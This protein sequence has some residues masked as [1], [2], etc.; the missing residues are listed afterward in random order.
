MIRMLINKRAVIRL[1]DDPWSRWIWGSHLV[2]IVSHFWNIAAT[3]EG[4]KEAVRGFPEQVSNALRDI[5]RGEGKELGLQDI[6]PII[7]QLERMR[8]GKMANIRWPAARQGVLEGKL[9]DD[10]KEVARRAAIVLLFW[11]L[12][13]VI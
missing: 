1:C 10:S 4:G 9:F 6:F 13:E 2:E 5:W 8:P 12:R 11:T 3:K 7:S